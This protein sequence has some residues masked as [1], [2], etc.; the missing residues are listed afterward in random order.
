MENYLVS[1]AIGVEL[2]LNV[3]EKKIY[4]PDVLFLRDKNIK[5]IDIFN[6]SI[7]PKVLSGNSTSAEVEQMKI[8]LYD[9]SNQYEFVQNLLLY[10]LSYSNSNNANRLLFNRKLDLQKCFVDVSNIADADL[11][12]KSVYFV[13]YYDEPIFTNLKYID[14]PKKII[15]SLEL[16]LNGLKTYF[17]ENRDLVNLSFCDLQLSFPKFTA[18]GNTGITEGLQ[19]KHFLTLSH[20]NKEFFYRVP[21]NLFF[22]YKK[23]SFVLT[24]QNIKFDLLNS[25][26]ESVDL[27]NDTKSIYFNTISNK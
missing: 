24:L 11:L 8:T 14:S 2:Q 26:I 16:K 5:Y 23:R 21:I 10:N 3:N 17:L 15:K 20:K 27:T 4:L 18:I 7:L 12:N 6:S 19:S 22:Q 13:F 1:G 25:Y 9:K